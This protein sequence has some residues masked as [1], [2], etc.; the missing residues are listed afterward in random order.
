LF[1]YLEGNTADFHRKFRIQQNIW[2]NLRTGLEPELLPKRINDLCRDPVNFTTSGK[3]EVLA[4]T[5]N[6]WTKFIGISVYRATHIFRRQPCAFVVPEAYV[7]IS[8]S[9]S[10]RS[11]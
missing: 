2:V 3:K 9:I 11:F 1:Y 4:I 10:T 8:F 7:K 6:E 5:G